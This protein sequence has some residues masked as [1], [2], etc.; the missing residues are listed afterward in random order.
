MS[1]K[2]TLKKLDWLR[3]VQEEL[4]RAMLEQ[5]RRRFHNLE[6]CRDAAAKSLGEGQLMWR[7]GI[8]TADAMGRQAAE[9]EMEMQRQLLDRYQS[10]LAE[11]GSELNRLLE[12]HKVRTMERRQ[13]EELLSI[14]KVAESAEDARRAQQGLDDWYGRRLQR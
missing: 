7:R 9:R 13:V 3:G 2:A 1:S 12:V 14:C 6:L 5:A 11:A 8:A 4:S 10:K